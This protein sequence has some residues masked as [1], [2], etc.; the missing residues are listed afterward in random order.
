MVWLTVKKH[1]PITVHGPLTPLI[2]LTSDS[3]DFLPLLNGFLCCQP[4]QRD[5]PHLPHHPPAFQNNTFPVETWYM[6]LEMTFFFS[7]CLHPGSSTLTAGITIHYVCARKGCKE[8]GR[9]SHH[10]SLSRPVSEIITN[11][12]KLPVSYFIFY[13]HSYKT[14][15]CLEN[16]DAGWG[17]HELVAGPLLEVMLLYSVSISWVFPRP[18]FIFSHSSLS[19]VSKCN[20]RVLFC[21]PA[22][23]EAVLN[24]EQVLPAPGLMSVREGCS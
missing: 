13:F 16:T 7:P 24:P 2:C 15:W 23:T 1:F 12:D 6:H 11:T 22:N 21:Q 19:P 10:I 18:F 20:L 9:S 3:L 5:L 17:R 8:P 4:F 14:G